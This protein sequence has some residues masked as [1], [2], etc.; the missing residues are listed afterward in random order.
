MCVPAQTI[1]IAELL[2]VQSFPYEIVKDMTQES[3]KDLV[4]NA[5]AEAAK[6]SA[7]ASKA[8]KGTK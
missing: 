1:H 2:D 5:R 3:A 4:Y 8:V 7:K 6:I